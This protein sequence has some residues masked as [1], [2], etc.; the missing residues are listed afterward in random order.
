[1]AQAAFIAFSHLEL[2]GVLHKFISVLRALHLTHI[3]LDLMAVV[4]SF[5]CSLE[6]ENVIIFSPD[7]G[8]FESVLV[9]L[10]QLMS[11]EH[12]LRPIN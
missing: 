6:F 7:V 4:A 10:A 1:M 5:A 2:L 3:F 12:L 9:T 11:Q 8:S